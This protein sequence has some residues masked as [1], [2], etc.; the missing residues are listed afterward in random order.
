MVADERS[1]ESPKFACDE[2]IRLPEGEAP[3]P[4]GAQADERCQSGVQPVFS[5]QSERA[6]RDFGTLLHNQGRTIERARFSFSLR[7][8][9]YASIFLP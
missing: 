6:W 5:G 4:K 7:H 3:A 2:V 8:R 1:E 9:A